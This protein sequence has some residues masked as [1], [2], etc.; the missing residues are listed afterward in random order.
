MDSDNR[1]RNGAEPV[2]AQRAHSIT[3]T[4][5]SAR[6]GDPDI[7]TAQCACGWQGGSFAAAVGARIAR[8]QAARHIDEHS[9]AW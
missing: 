3:V 8:R 6:F 2:L 4:A 1:R 9:P 7:F 5:E